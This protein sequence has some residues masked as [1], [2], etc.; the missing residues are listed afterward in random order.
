[1][2]N[3]I[4]LVNAVA[5]VAFKNGKV[6]S[7]GHSFVK[8]CEYTPRR[9]VA[10][11]KVF[12]ASFASSSATVSVD[13]AISAAQ[14]ALDGKHNN[15]PTTLEYLVNADNTASLVHVVQVQNADQ[16]TWYEAFVDAHSGKFISSIDLVANA[17]VGRSFQ[18]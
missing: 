6:V 9:R 4:P 7:F 11:L 2:Q 18:H 3:N 10:S 13:A 15:I 8:P 14:S 17:V 12:Q 1:L 5:N 16:G